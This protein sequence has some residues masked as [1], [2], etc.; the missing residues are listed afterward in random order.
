M[1]SAIVHASMVRLAEDDKIVEVV[2]RVLEGNVEA[3]LKLKVGIKRSTWLSM[4]RLRVMILPGH[5]VELV[6]DCE[7]DLEFAQTVVAL[8]FVDETLMCENHK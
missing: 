5:R 4:D 2:A 3:G 6:P 8:N 1:K 7:D